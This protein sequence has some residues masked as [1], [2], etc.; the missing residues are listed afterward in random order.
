[1]KKGTAIALTALAL[2]ALAGVVSS[3]SPRH[4][5]QVYVDATAMIEK[6]DY[7]QALPL[8]KEVV[9]D[10]TEF[11]DAHYNLGFVYERLG[12]ADSAMQEYATA[13]SIDS[14]L[15]MAHY[16][17]G[18]LALRT[19]DYAGAIRHL[20]T[21]VSLDTTLVSAYFNLGTALDATDDLDG[22][23]AV[24]SKVVSVKPDYVDAYYQLAASLYRK[25]TS[26]QGYPAVIEA[27]KKALEMGADH[28]NAAVAHFYLARMYLATS[29]HEQA[30]ASADAAVKIR[31]DLAQAYFIKGK[32]LVSLGRDDEAATEFRKAIEKKPG[33]GSAHYALGRLLQ[34]K[35]QYEL[36]LE[37]Y[38]NATK[39][40]GFPEAESAA[41]AVK[42][43]EDYLRKKAEQGG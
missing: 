6:G 43:L 32:A 17:M 11:A 25:A 37:Q 31:P 23:V 22:A 20:R 38:R 16:G 29:Q 26:A 19:Q 12:Y 13:L 41:K 2:L 40:P 27:Y 7:P 14:L 39:D 33:Y 21:A 15:V 3:Q 24:L 36:A 30:A 42:A 9:A 4:A 8:L 1:M 34:K 10:S 18:T 28:V 5:S 35:E